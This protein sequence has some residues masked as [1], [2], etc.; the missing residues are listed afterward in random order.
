MEQRKEPKKMNNPIEAYLGDFSA[1][2][3][4]MV[5]LRSGCDTLPVDTLAL[6][7]HIA[8]L[9]YE[10]IEKAEISKDD[11][12][13]TIHIPTKIHVGRAFWAEQIFHIII[14][15]IDDFYPNKAMMTLC[16]D[17]FLSHLLCPRVLFQ[18]SRHAW[19]SS[20][21]LQDKFGFSQYSLRKLLRC[22]SCYVPRELNI[23]LMQQLKPKYQSYLLDDTSND[24][25]LYQ[26]L[27]GYEDEEACLAAV[28]EMDLE[29]IQKAIDT[30][31]PEHVLTE[32]HP[33]SLY[34]SYTE[35]FQ[36]F[37][38]QF[39]KLDLGLLYK[40]LFFEDPPE[41]LLGGRPQPDEDNYADRYATY[42][43][44][45]EAARLSCAQLFFQRKY[46]PADPDTLTST[47]RELYARGPI[48]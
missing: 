35:D 7:Q 11:T 2:M 6:L 23:R 31:I 40:A 8:K 43:L 48:K 45:E 27:I 15:N 30:V 1:S 29:P 3:A 17:E 5:L 33:A 12:G 38:K 46:H 34:I 19:S 22:P 37:Y 14:D 42:L 44:R 4:T 47:I 39:G 18:M 10:D 32:G 16:F 36:S 24:L 26:F 13:Y 20:K 41:P 9:S 25:S 28:P 21:A